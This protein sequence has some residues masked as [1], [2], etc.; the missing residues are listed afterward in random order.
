MGL[1]GGVH[2]FM[3]TISLTDYPIISQIAVVFS[4][5]LYELTNQIMD[6]QVYTILSDTLIFRDNG[7]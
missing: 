2:L 4:V 3:L 1:S 5:T 7:V 6:N